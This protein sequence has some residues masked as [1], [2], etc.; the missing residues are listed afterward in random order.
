MLQLSHIRIRDPFVLLEDDTYYMYASAANAGPVEREGFNVYRS[1]DL[2]NWEG[3]FRVFDPAPDFWADRDFWAPE[4]HKYKGRFY[5][6]AS[7]KAEGVHRGSQILVADSPMGP[8]SPLSDGPITPAGWDCLDATLFVDKDGRPYTFYCH[9]WMQITDGTMVCQKLTDDLTAPAGEPVTLFKASDPDWSIPYERDCYVTDAP[10]L[11][12][13]TDGRLLMIW[14]SYGKKGYVQAQAE[15]L[16]GKPEGPWK[17]LSPIFMEDGGHGM[18]FTDKAGKRRLALHQPNGGNL[19][20]ARF[21]YLV[22]KEGRLAA[23]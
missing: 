19:E 16:T 6:F 18:I 7:F 2:Q 4:V 8:F 12:W 15:S 20:R 17:Q 13:T 14:S 11:H 23:E 22:E 1:Q 10:F 9:E 21:F 5:M 3:P